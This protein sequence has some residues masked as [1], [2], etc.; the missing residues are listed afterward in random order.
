MSSRQSAPPPASGEE[1]IGRPNPWGEGR[2]EEGG[3]PPQESVVRKPGE[4]PPDTT[5]TPVT[6]KD[7]ESP[8]AG[9]SL[10]G[11]AAAGP[12]SSGPTR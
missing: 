12:A 4:G 3:K 5:S 2:Y 6:R 8:P 9:G 1:A 7:Y 11:S 10:P